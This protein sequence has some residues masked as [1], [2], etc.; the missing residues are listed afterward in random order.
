[1]NKKPKYFAQESENDGKVVMLYC[2]YSDD[3]IYYE[4]DG[5]W[6]K[7]DWQTDVLNYMYRQPKFHPCSLADVRA[8]FNNIKAHKRDSI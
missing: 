2:V 8:V 4:N 3:Q 1:M 6:I 5:K 7:T